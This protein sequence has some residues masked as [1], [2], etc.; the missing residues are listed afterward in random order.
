[1]M[2]LRSVTKPGLKRDHWF[3]LWWING[4]ND[5]IKHICEQTANGTAQVKYW[6]YYLTAISRKVKYHTNAIMVTG[7]VHHHLINVGLRADAN[8]I[9]ETGLVRDSHN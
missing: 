4:L 5:A 6:L 9:I 2:Q 7:A 1:M 8:L 3:K